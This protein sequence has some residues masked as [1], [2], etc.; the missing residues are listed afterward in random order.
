M[1]HLRAGV[2]I[3]ASPARAWEILTDFESF[4]S[5]NPFIRSASGRLVPGGQLEVKLRLGRLPI[6]LRPR[7]T[8]VDEPRELRWRA[9]QFVPG[10]FDVDRRFLLQP[11][12]ATTCRFHQSETATGI[13]A[14][15]IM[16]L[17]RRQ[18]LHGYQ[19]MNSALKRRAE[20]V[21]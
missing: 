11:I 17:L 4:P 3:Q 16:P 2:D 18:I 21:G 20:H 8:V 5:W 9:R 10:L 13:L 7:L 14:P 15:L 12:D 19:E 6:T 1:R